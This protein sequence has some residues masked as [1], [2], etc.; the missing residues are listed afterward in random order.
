MEV[1]RTS[2]FQYSLYFGY[3]KRHANQVR[4][5]WPLAKNA[6]EPLY[7]GDQLRTKP[8]CVIRQYLGETAYSQIIPSPRIRER[9]GLGAILSTDVVVNLVVVPLRVERRIDVAEIHRLVLDLL[10]KDVKVVTVEELLHV[11][12]QASFVYI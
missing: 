9:L 2:L 5:Q 7:Q 11:R 6:V 4:E 10:P 3:S 8:T 12:G 1:K